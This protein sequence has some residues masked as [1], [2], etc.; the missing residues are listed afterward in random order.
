[1]S[2]E[3]AHKDAEHRYTSELTAAA[4][5]LAERQAEH[6]SELAHAAAARH[7]LQQQLRDA[8]TAHERAQQDHAA[9]SAAASERFTRREAELGATLQEALAIRSALE[10][11]LA[12]AE[13]ARLDAEQQRES[14]LTTAAALLAERQAQYDAEVAKAAAAA[15]HLTRREA[16]LGGRIEE[17]LAIQNALEH[18]LTALD[19][20]RQLAEQR[21]S[22][23]RATAAQHQAEFDAR[24]TEETAA[25]NAIE[26]KLAHAEAALLTRQQELGEA[27]AALKHSEEQRASEAAV[28]AEHLAQRNAE[29]TLGVAEVARSRDALG[30]QLSDATATIEQARM[31]RAAEAA[32][33]AEHL[34]RREA[35]LGAT[36]ADAIAAQNILQEKLTEA[37]A[38]LQHVERHASRRATELEDRLAQETLARAA[39]EQNLADAEAALQA[40]EERRTSEQT[41]AEA[42]LAECQSQCHDVRLAEATAGLEALGQQVRDGAVALERVQQHHAAETAA[43]AQQLTRRE[44]ELTHL[45]GERLSLQQSLATT[46][47]QVKHLNETLNEEREGR[48][49]ERLTAEAD[50]RKALAEYDQ[51]QR[52]L[53]QVRADF[54]S[55]ATLSSEHAAERARLGTVVTER[56]AQLRAQAERHVAAQQASKG[57]LT[58]IEDKLRLALEAGRRDVAKLQA[59]LAAVSREL[60][61]TRGQRDAL[62]IEADRVPPLQTQLD[63]RRAEIRRLFE[64]TPYGISRWNRDGVVTHVNR[65]LVRLLGYRSADD[66]RSVDFTTRVFESADD[67]RWLIERCLSTSGNETIETVWKRKDGGRRAM[68]LVAFAAGTESVEIVAEDITDLR[69]MKDQLHQARRMEAVG[70]LAAE[71]A[72][73]CDNLLRD[74]SQ[75]GQQWLATIGSDIALRQQ[76]EHLLGEVTRAASFLRK[77]AAYGEQQTSA[78]EPVDVNQVLRGLEPVLKRVA[79]DEI[80]FVLPKASRAVHVDVEVERVE[81]ILV[82]VAS[83]AR[84]RMPFG[85]QLKIDLAAVVVDRKFLAKYPNVRPGAHALITVTEEKGAKRADWPIGHPNKSADTNAGRSASDNPGVDLGVLLGLVG[86]CGG[87][88]W[89][90]AEPN[91]N[92]VLKIHLPQRVSDGLT[93]PHAP[94]TRSV[95]GRAM[96]RWFGH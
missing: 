87:H 48:E 58:E 81:R 38:T 94:A 19:G 80:H 51:V 59:E 40:A 33:A 63:E 49:R 27:H 17:A 91:G 16:E 4:A 62:R 1:M 71:V 8:T 64:H 82:N 37:E 55:L 44:T 28:A 23:E 50:R 5:R 76:G 68:R 45:Q 32:A 72:L 77:L 66:L 26:E 69:A 35:E 42:Y 9:A 83:Y 36:L 43:A 31:T 79:G 15:Q 73:T 29:F 24:L 74:V 46:Q 21:V 93:D 78:L 61:A 56:D 14:E 95:R 86:D 67:L 89:M 2:A 52:T 20:A 7:A 47:E 25:R 84:E 34:K 39:L 88:V 57:A 85:G 53:E 10:Q 12:G 60:D 54:Q 41:A 65:A 90:A 75:D 22:I 96:A 13:A 70:R 30:Q 11:K 18:R 3:A 6:D 92:M